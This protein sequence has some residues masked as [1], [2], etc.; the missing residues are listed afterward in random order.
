M[1]AIWNDQVIAESSETIVIEGNHYFPPDS[2]NREYFEQSE[3][4]TTCSW[5][6]VASYFI[7][8]VDGK[9]N[10]DAAWTYSEPKSAASEI[11]DY[12]AFWKG[13]QVVG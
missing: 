7:L 8:N 12:V 13:V 6:G 11:K 5:K 4:K 1:K 10:P 9:S 2:L 3:T